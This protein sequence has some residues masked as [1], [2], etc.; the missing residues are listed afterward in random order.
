MSSEKRG[1]ALPT[2]RSGIQKRLA[3]SPNCSLGQSS[4]KPLYFHFPSLVT[5]VTLSFF[6]P[7]AFTITMCRHDVLFWIQSYAATKYDRYLW[8]DCGYLV[9]LLCDT[10]TCDKSGW[11]STNRVEFR[12]SPR[13]GKS[14]FSCN[15]FSDSATIVVP[16]APASSQSHI[17]NWTRSDSETT[18]ALQLRLEFHG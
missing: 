4:A 5:L 9:L 6:S 1:S 16:L 8:C 10:V 17:S 2:T 3:I 15:V 11:N 14:I 7:L 12:A 18:V 13:R